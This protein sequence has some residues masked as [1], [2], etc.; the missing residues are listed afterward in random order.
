MQFQ[1]IYRE[2]TEALQRGDITHSAACW[3]ELLDLE[4]ED[5][6]AL[7]NLAFC[8]LTLG[9]YKET[10]NICEKGNV[11]VPGNLEFRRLRAEAAY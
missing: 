2:G 5:E 10:I 9:N 11:L 7:Q 6:V 8:H 3:D 4:P 1:D